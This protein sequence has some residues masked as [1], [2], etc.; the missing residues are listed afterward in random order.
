MDKKN[1][2]K[3]DKKGYFR[4]SKLE[5][6][7]DLKKLVKA[8]V[9]DEDGRIEIILGKG[10][11]AGAMLRHGFIN[12]GRERSFVAEVHKDRILLKPAA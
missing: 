5:G 12:V 9:K 2:V 11:K 6:C 10:D 4:L 1:L 8:T 7:P 3:G